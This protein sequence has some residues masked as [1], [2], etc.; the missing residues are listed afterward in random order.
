MEH[1]LQPQYGIWSRLWEGTG[2]DSCMCGFQSHIQHRVLIVLAVSWLQL[3]DLKHRLSWPGALENYTSIWSRLLNW[4]YEQFLPCSTIWAQL[5]RLHHISSCI[6]YDLEVVCHDV[7]VAF[8]LF[9]L[10]SVLQ[11]WSGGSVWQK[12][13]LLEKGKKHSTQVDRVPTGMLDV[14]W[15]TGGWEG[16]SRRGG[17]SWRL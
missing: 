11:I 4:R 17:A 1:Y 9:T 3:T 10:C 5:S 14:R 12:W 7:I 8:V 2:G 15:R 6:V 16:E 13:K